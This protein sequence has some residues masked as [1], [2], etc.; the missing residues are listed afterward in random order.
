[1]EKF[2]EY[3]NY[4]AMGLSELIQTCEVS[5]A[6]LVDEAIARIEQANPK[7]N[8]VV[9]TMYRQAAQ[10]AQQALP[11]TPFKGVPFLIKDLGIFAKDTPTTSG[12]AF[13]EDFMAAKNDSLMQRYDDVGLLTLG[14]TNTPEFGLLPVT[15]GGLHGD[16]R[17]PWNIEHTA[18]GSSGG[19][20]AAVASGMV[21]I[22]H[23][24]DIGGSIRIPASCCGL[25]GLK[26]SRGRM[27]HQQFV[28]LSLGLLQSG[29]ISR[30]VRDT[31]AALDLT[32]G[33]R[34]GAVHQ[35]PNP[36]EGFLHLLE[37][38][39]KKLRIAIDDQSHFDTEVSA[40]CKAALSHSARLCE[41][42]GHTVEPA[43]PNLDATTMMIS[44]ITIVSAHT[45]HTLNVL[46][47][48]LGEAQKR[49][50]SSLLRIYAKI[51]RY[52]TAQQCLAA[53]E[54]MAQLGVE[55][56]QFHQQFDVYLTPTLGQIPAKIGTFIPNALMKKIQFLASHC[57][58]AKMLLKLVL[59]D[60]ITKKIF[61]FTPF[62]MLSNMTG[63]PSISLPLYWS[64]EGLPIGTLFNGRWGEEHV[65]LQ[66]AKQLE[67]AQ[68]WFNNRPKEF[69]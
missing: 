13:L 43:R 24:N 29:V 62:T 65:L 57:F 1:M 39:P 22:A 15:E 46:L 25:V 47:E 48:S 18:G 11:H 5:A 10:R 35:L 59:D 60:P 36:Q 50:P 44:F 52:F 54:S 9:Y 41:E 61:Q 17:N 16:C 31:A 40:Q 55:L 66:L 63:N 68:P 28:D 7:L 3:V 27:P 2:S 37:S 38:S 8:A 69:L 51:G 6:T 67:M 45:A 30:S 23:A 64:K 58:P 56:A 49:R 26:P 20:G 42:L 34:L 4:D 21:P 33:A 32:A 14:K 53:H 12:C 19:A